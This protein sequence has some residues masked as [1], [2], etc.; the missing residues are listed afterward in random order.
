MT[1]QLDANFDEIKQYLVAS[2]KGNEKFKDYN[3]EGSNLSALV[4]ILA[5]N[6]YF[7][8]YFIKMLFNEMVPSTAS[9]P[10]SL[11][12]H[13][14]RHGYLIKNAHPSSA[15]IKV[16]AKGTAQVQYV[17]IP[18]GTLFASTTPDNTRV[19]F[20]TLEQHTLT[21]RN[22]D[23]D[24]VGE[25]SIYEG[26]FKSTTF[27]AAGEVTYT[28]M[29]DDANIAVDYLFVEV[30]KGGGQKFTK[31]TRYNNTAPNKDDNVYYMKFIGGHYHIF[32]GGNQFGYQPQLDE[33]IKVTY[34]ITNGSA[35]NSA[36]VF[37]PIIATS[38]DS[39]DIGHYTAQV[40]TLSMASG[41]QSSVDYNVLGTILTNFNRVSS[42]AVTPEDY[43]YAV[44]DN[45]G[46]IGS[47]AV[48]GGASN[49]N[50]VDND[51]SQYGKLFMSI[52]PKGSDKLSNAAKDA[53][54]NYLQ[55]NHAIVGQS[56]VFVDPKYIDLDIDIT[57]TRT[58]EGR[59]V[60]SESIRTNIIKRSD[61][62]SKNE[63]NTF[64]S[65]LSFARYQKAV[66]DGYSDILYRV[67][68]RITLSHTIKITSLNQNYVVDFKND[69]SSFKSEVF[70]Y[71]NNEAYFTVLNPASGKVAISL[72]VN[73]VVSNGN[74]GTVDFDRGVVTLFV[75]DNTISRT[76]TLK[77]TTLSNDLGVSKSNILRIKNTSVTLQ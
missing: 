52:K 4:D 13:A 39:N 8:I 9:N 72:V 16:T 42:V 40:E 61:E 48:W 37:E 45:F 60:N 50:T 34:F 10:D 25:I 41:G 58:K 20:I 75:P 30:A 44:L 2:F 49:S 5:R 51:A 23:G 54:A 32:F 38:S 63:L 64:D 74:F 24:L 15:R 43:K 76:L 36:F 67:N 19:S 27:R 56:I 14:L 77:V 69:L 28:Y 66:F 26:T 65:G 29:L 1:M 53:I 73:G 3:F 12:A 31:F 46:D 68:T 35:A 33:L 57:A 55:K 6:T 7:N 47:I 62:F 17:T 11:V 71:G 21:D 59:D 18:L 22:A 70:T